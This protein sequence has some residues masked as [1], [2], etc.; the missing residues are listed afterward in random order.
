MQ[1]YFA[2]D[3]FVAR[4]AFLALAR[5]RGARISS[6]PIHARGPH[7][8][9]LGIDTAYLGADKPRRL[10]IVLCG[11]HG[12]EGFAGSAL[13]QQWL[14][15]GEVSALPPDGGCL[16]IHAVNPYGFAWLR[17]ANEHNVDLNRNALDAFPGPANAVYRS[18]DRWLNPPA[19][20][21]RLDMFWPRGAWQVLTRGFAPL[22]QA[23]VRGQYEFPRGLFFGG[24]RVEE[25]IAHLDQIISAQ[26]FR[27]VGRVIVIDL[28]TGLGPS[29]TYRLLVDVTADAPTFRHLARWFGADAVA[30]SQQRGSAVYEVSGGIVELIERRFPAANAYVGVLEIGTVPLPQ[31]LYRLYRENRAT[32]YC[33]PDDPVVARE[34]AA[35]REAFYPSRPNWRERVATHGERVFHQALQAL[36]DDTT[37]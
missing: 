11:T 12:V 28:H 1:V 20:P 33:P 3:Y 35:L 26:A 21:R 19:P 8:E 5:N 25:S 23:I 22:R 36:R 16:L 32:F 14:D 37:A 10:L 7:G 24:E 13:Q 27:N 29:A 6:Y 4:E 2:P 34:R 17:R 31:M 18:L 30:S 9:T 15:R